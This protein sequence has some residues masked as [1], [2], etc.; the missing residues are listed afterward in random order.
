[1]T[2][3]KFENAS[4]KYKLYSQSGLYL[5]DRIT[6]ALQ[7]LNPLNGRS[8]FPMADPPSPVAPLER[9]FWALKNISFEIKQGE[10][11]GFIGRNGAGKST[12]LKL[13]AGVTKAT[14]GTVEVK[15]RV[16]ALIEVGAGFHPELTGREN[17]YLNGSILGMRRA[18]IE[19]KFDSIVAF[20]ELEDFIDT[21]VKHY[22]SGMYVRLGFAIAAHTNP[23]IYLIDEVLAVGDEAFQKKCLETLAAHKAAGKTMIL[24][25][26]ALA[27]IEEVCDRCIYVS[28][29]EV[30]YDG[31]PVQSI[32]QYLADLERK[33][34]PAKKSVNEYGADV[35]IVDLIFR[36]RNNKQSSTFH[37]NDDLIIEV[38]YRA[39]QAIANPVVNLLIYGPQGEYVSGFNTRTGSVEIVEL[40]GEGSLYCRIKDLPLRK[41]RYHI[42]AG[43]HD[44]SFTRT[45]DHH[46]RR[47]RLNVE[48]VEARTHGLVYL[49]E[50]WSRDPTFR[51]RPPSVAKVS[52]ITKLHGSSG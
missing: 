39:K 3:I 18:E 16:A 8:L 40:N 10:S 26:H 23:D 52:P 4:K 13:L 6:H 43:I 20:A 19:K 31:S 38:R 25:S 50:E 36:D 11:V 37:M 30:R 14:S 1:M 28:H 42:T 44:Y 9:D 12:I 24:V 51:T 48:G 49:K 29:G 2:V 21:P 35:E 17:I 32:K 47:Y 7:R 27:K 46:D 22:S 5:R 34:T 33:G 45:Y 15:G 41:G